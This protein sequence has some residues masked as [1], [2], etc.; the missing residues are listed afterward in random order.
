[1]IREPVVMESSTKSRNQAGDIGMVVRAVWSTG[2]RTPAWDRLWRAILVKRDPEGLD[3][4]GPQTGRA[5][6][7]A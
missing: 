2:P 6:D 1:V 7:D 4:A 3:D 5:G